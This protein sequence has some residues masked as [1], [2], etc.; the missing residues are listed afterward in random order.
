M[1]ENV[2]VDPSPRRIRVMFGGETVADSTHAQCVWTRGFPPIPWYYFPKQDV[3]QE[4]LTA[5]DHTT[6][7]EFLGDAR[8]WSVKAGD[9]VAENAAHAYPDSPVEAM[10]DLIGFTW[11]KM[12]MWLEEDEQIFVH[13]RDPFHRVDVLHSSRH[14]EIAIDGVTVADSKRARLL[15]ETGMPTRYYLPKLDVQMEQL[16]Q[17]D[18]ETSCPYKGNAVYWSVKVGG[19]VHSD[20]AWGYRTPLAVVAK[21]A[22]LVCFYNEK[23]DITVDGKKQERPITGFVRDGRTFHGPGAKR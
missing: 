14:I 13:P 22:D 1:T 8:H 9:R 4:L 7:E 19:T 18:T 6:S 2:H 12:D 10:R 11:G 15:F 21:L 3:R 16:K 20:M 5:S 23:V 17:T